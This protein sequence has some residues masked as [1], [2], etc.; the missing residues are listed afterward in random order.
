LRA[1][2]A[3]EMMYR[4][5]RLIVKLLSYIP[6]SISQYLGKM[7]GTVFFLAP[8]ER[9]KVVRE[10]IRK[11][12]G[13][14]L[15]ETA[16]KRLLRKVYVHF[17][18]MIFEIPH[19]LKFNRN[20]LGRYVQFVN[21]EAYVNAINKGKGVFFLTG[22]I[23]NWE[24]ISPS[25]SLHFGGFSIVARPIDFR[26]ADQLVE[27]IRTQF[28]STIIPKQKAMRR[29]LKAI[30]QRETVGILLD[31]NVD[32]YDG[33]FVKFLGRWACT[34]KG[35]ALIALKTGAPVIP[36]FSIRQ[37][38]GR[39]CIIFEDEVKLVQTGDKTKD[40]EENTALF[41]RII[42]DYVRQY[43][44]QWFWFHRRWKTRMYWPIQNIKS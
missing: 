29:I 7:I 22:H 40:I 5:I 32:W 15:D 27:D 13:H 2:K 24:F 9:K 26:P 12:F 43:P 44:E 19:T 38:N 23:G 36:L 30:K 18:Q 34:N 6:F 31:Q 42:E 4:L 35:L 25:I 37:G 10:N 3:Y 17:G 21:E 28:G 14:F 16:I 41:T 20:N 33:V 39:Y 8:I 1:E 11:S